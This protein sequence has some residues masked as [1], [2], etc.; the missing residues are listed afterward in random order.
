MSWNFESGISLSQQIVSRIRAEIIGGKY[1]PGDQF[2]TVRH[3]AYEASVNPN[4]V[5]KALTAL[6]VEGL[7]V[8]R[9]TV[10]RF[11]TNDIEV[12]EKARSTVRT[13]YMRHV[14]EEAHK[15]GIDDQAFIDFIK[16]S[17]GMK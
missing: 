16:E 8:A 12:I 3:L 13:E 1:A 17:E 6:E 2:P 15:L 14:L 4:T 9:G 7:L 5:Q 11:V 10:G